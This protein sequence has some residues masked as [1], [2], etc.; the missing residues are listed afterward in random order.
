VEWNL[1]YAETCCAIQEHLFVFISANYPTGGEP[2][3]T[4]DHWYV[5]EHMLK[6]LV[7]FYLSTVSLSGVYYP[8]S[9]V[10]MH[11]II[12][13][14]SLIKDWEQG[15]TTWR[16]MSW[17]R[18]WSTSTWMDMDLNDLM[19][20]LLVVVLALLQ[21]MSLVSAG[22]PSLVSACLADTI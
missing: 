8:T 4:D 18:R 13:M 17:K 9:P 5:V 7:V 11:A 20:L 14:L 10:M 2:L 12:E 6:F 21:K 16:T 19:V 15:D 3:L 22:K 1:S